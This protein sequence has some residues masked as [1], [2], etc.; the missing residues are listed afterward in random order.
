[1]QWATILWSCKA[2]IEGIITIAFQRISEK[3]EY[4]CDSMKMNTGMSASDLP[5]VYD[6]NA[7]DKDKSKVGFGRGGGGV[8]NTA[9]HQRATCCLCWDGCGRSSNKN[10]S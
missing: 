2:P 1:M 8:G 3:A 6:E 4:E 5:N 9:F 10:S 7:E